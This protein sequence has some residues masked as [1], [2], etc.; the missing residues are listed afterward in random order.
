MTR[1]L[2]RT[3]LQPRLQNTCCHPLFRSNRSPCRH[4]ERSVSKGNPPLSVVI[5]LTADAGS[6]DDSIRR[7]LPPPAGIRLGFIAVLQE[8][9]L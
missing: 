6:M 4:A 3:W 8:L 2:R 1:L 7:I 5:K 9:R